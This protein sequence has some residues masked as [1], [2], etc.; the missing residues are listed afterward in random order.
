MKSEIATAKVIIDGADAAWELE[1][2][3]KKSKELK[4]EM[5]KAFKAGDKEGFIKAKKQFDQIEGSMTKVKN[6]GIDITRVMK[7]LN[8]TN[9]K[10]LVQA[11]KQIGNE[12]RVMTR[13]TAEYIAKSKQLHQISTEV[14][15]VKTEMKGLSS[16]T[17]NA[18]LSL[19]N[20]FGAFTLAS[21][22]SQAITQLFSK[23]KEFLSGSTDAFLEAEKATQQLGFAVKQVGGGS[24]SDLAKL[25]EQA[26]KLKGYFDDEAIRKAQTDLLNY[27]LTADQVYT[28]I[29]TLLDTSAQ[30]GRDLNDVSNAVIRGMEGQAKGLKTLGV[31]FKDTGDSAQNLSIIQEQL[32][33]FTGGAAAA[34]ETEGG[35]LKANAVMLNDQQEE[36]G[37]YTTKS[38]LFFS[39]IG[40]SIAKGV[41]SVISFIKSHENLFKIIKIVGAAIATYTGIILVVAAA[42]KVYTTAVNIARYANEAF[43]KSMKTTVWGAVAA[44]IVAVVTGIVQFSK[45]IQETK[46]Q[47]KEFEQSID[48]EVGAS[49]ALFEQLKKTNPQSEDRA[50]I[51]KL[52]NEKYGDYL[53][54]MD[55]EK[56]S[57]EE[58]ETAQKNVNNELITNLTLK[59]KNQAVTD[60]AQTQANILVKLGEKGVYLNDLTE[61]KGALKKYVIWADQEIQSLSDAYSQL[62]KEMD[63]IS[64]KYDEIAEGIRKS[65]TGGSISPKE[66]KP[67]KPKKGNDDAGKDAEARLKAILESTKKFNDQFFIELQSEDDKEK[68]LIRQKYDDKLKELNI[69]EQKINEIKAK[70]WDKAS[71]LEKAMWANYDANIDAMNSE[72][73]AKEKEHQDKLEQAKLAAQEEIWQATLKGEEAE[74]VSAMQK[75]DKLFELAYQNGVDT[76]VLKENMDKEM[77]LIHQK[78]LD[79]EVAK[80]KEAEDKKRKERQKSLQTTAEIAGGLLNIVNGI[81]Q[82]ELEKA[83]D[84][85]EKKKAIQKKYADIQMVITIGKIIAATAMGAMQAYELGPV[86][87][88]I[89]SGV[90]IGE[91]IIEAGYAIAQ[92]NKIKSLDVGGPTGDGY[93][94]PD[95]SGFKVAGVVHQNEYVIPAWLRKNPQVAAFE[96]IIESMRVNRTGYASGGASSITNTVTPPQI[97]TMTEAASMLSL[98]T[99]IRTELKKTPRAKLVYSDFENMDI[100]VKEIRSDI[101]N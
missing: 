24:D 64:L 73:E 75:Y 27:G 46:K 31:D 87:G 82:I 78:Y 67:I 3:K 89:M 52:I 8:G 66:K 93:G 13:G 9:L 88:A 84:N 14:N 45:S 98:L 29:P 20:L 21:L 23:T 68:E 53:H 69:N 40:L 94:Y 101:G 50:R 2:L 96:N 37:I 32:Q 81:Q 36:L 74:M 42:K 58:I 33:K 99:D 79:N 56:A 17:N 77:A 44:A 4:V 25:N 38:K 80:T 1:N 48:N 34:L 39:E 72:I 18:A 22:A 54:G 15:K 57:L 85:E 65:L 92:R 60:I 61:G 35:K 16:G 30:S 11:E 62:G 41:S 59:A 55:L 26:D 63:E 97:V 70:G 95:E 83:G 76:A 71:D 49:N 19:K 100:K 5:D 43:S 7:N 86:A 90:I 51:I 91:G 28:L 12:L 10:D 6:T 47:L